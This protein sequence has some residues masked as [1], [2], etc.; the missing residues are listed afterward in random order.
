MREEVR[1][2]VVKV[3]NVKVYIADDGTEFKHSYDCRNYE[4]EKLKKPLLD[5]LVKCEEASSMPNCDGSYTSDLNE[6]EWYFVRNQED[7]D[8]LNEVLGIGL[9]EKHIGEWVCV[10]TDDGCDAWATTAS[11]G[12]EYVIDLLTKLGYKV[13]ITRE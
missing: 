13:E 6:Y 10:E 3:T 7:V 5:K 2:E 9:S 12:I 8:I 1:E 11:D 4:W